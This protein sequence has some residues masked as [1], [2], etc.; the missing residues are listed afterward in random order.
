MARTSDRNSPATKELLIGPLRD[1][2][3]AYTDAA[4]T[5]H[6]AKAEQRKWFRVAK[7]MLGVH[8]LMD[9]FGMSKQEV[10]AIIDG[11]D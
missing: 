5:M 4:S 6:V 7:E 8:G 11:R 3:Q 2:R 1:A 9:D 10:E